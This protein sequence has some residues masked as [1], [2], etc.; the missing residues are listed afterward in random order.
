M[1]AAYPPHAEQLYFTKRRTRYSAGHGE[2]GLLYLPTEGSELSV[3]VKELEKNKGDFLYR[4]PWSVVASLANP[5]LQKFWTGA[6]L[7]RNTILEE[8][9]L[10][11]TN[12]LKR[13]ARSRLENSAG[14]AGTQKRLPIV[15]SYCCDTV[16]AKGRSAT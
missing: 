13:V 15:L 12:L 6:R 3:E 9:I 14:R 2:T 16:E 5:T 1:P 10:Y 4:Q 8:A 11:F 7:G